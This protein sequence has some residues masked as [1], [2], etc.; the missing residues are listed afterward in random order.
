MDDEKTESSGSES[1][2]EEEFS[3]DIGDEDSEDVVVDK[4]SLVF[5]DSETREQES[6]QGE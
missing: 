6:E 2:L 1:E 4:P 5:A 3:R